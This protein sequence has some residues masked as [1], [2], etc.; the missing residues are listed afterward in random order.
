MEAANVN[1][2]APGVEGKAQAT[3]S[4]TSVLPPDFTTLPD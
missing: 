4:H 1:K 3:A 2:R